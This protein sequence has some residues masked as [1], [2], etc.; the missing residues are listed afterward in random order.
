MDTTS[1]GDRMKVYENLERAYLPK[2]SFVVLRLDG[3]AFHSLTKGMER[4]FDNNFRLCMA[5]AMKCLCENVAGVKFAY[6]Q[7]DEIS[8]LLSDKA[9]EET[10]PWFGNNLQKLVSVS[11]SIC[12][13]YFNSFFGVCPN[14]TRSNFSDDFLPKKQNGFGFA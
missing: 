6:T 2:N 10:E 13:V 9:S 3:K 8:L 7:S 4:P 12:T 5:Y 1:L 14:K 11:S